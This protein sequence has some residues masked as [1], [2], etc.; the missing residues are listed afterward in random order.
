M[1]TLMQDFRYGLRVLRANPAFTITAALCVAPWLAILSA[2][3]LR[4]ISP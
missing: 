2:M 3:A 4:A 1:N